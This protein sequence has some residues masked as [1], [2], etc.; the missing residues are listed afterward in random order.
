MLGL[1]L[2]S[3]AMWALRVAFFFATALAA[4][5]NVGSWIHNALQE[6]GYCAGNGLSWLPDLDVFDHNVP[7]RGRACDTLN[8]LVFTALTYTIGI[9]ACFAFSALL[10]PR[11]YGFGSTVA[12]LVS[13]GLWLLFAA[14]VLAAF[15]FQRVGDFVYV[16]GGLVLYTF[17]TYV[18]TAEMAVKIEAG[19]D[20]VIDHA[21]N[22][23]YNFL[24]MFI[25]IIT[26][27]GEAKK[28]EAEAERRKKSK[29]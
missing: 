12:T 19:D 25:R 28:R 21:L 17:K 14:Q 9:Y 20:D 1:A 2:T 7:G 29:E 15:G 6:A 4:G 26:L 23:L 27:L 5:L 16:R 8:T 24:H 10:S 13:A 22:H 11:K 18:D 3:K